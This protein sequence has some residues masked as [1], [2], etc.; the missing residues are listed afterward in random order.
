MKLKVNSMLVY[1]IVYTPEYA[2]V[3]SHENIKKGQYGYIVSDVMSYEEIVETYG[4]DVASSIVNSGN[5]IIAHRPLKQN[6]IFLDN[7]EVLPPFG[8][9][10]PT[11]ITCELFKSYYKDYEGKVHSDLVPA[12][13]FIKGRFQWLGEYSF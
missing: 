10:R 3:V 12:T 9:K 6:I 7:T 2:I 5:R 8:R 13:K 11:S 1:N 4:I